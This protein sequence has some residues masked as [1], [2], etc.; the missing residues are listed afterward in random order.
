[1][2]GLEWTR[3]KYAATG[4]RQAGKSAEEQKA[5]QEQARQ[6]DEAINGFLSQ[7]MDQNARARLN[8]LKLHKPER[9]LMVEE[10]IVRVKKAGQIPGI[11]DE[12]TLI[13][14]L[15]D[16]NSQCPLKTFSV[17]FDRRRAAIDSDDEDDYGL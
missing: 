9:A 10:M 5:A 4:A 15:E 16:V 8:A 6:Q 3:E 7:C 2:D 14:I 11:I 1:M 12:P 13:R 17:K